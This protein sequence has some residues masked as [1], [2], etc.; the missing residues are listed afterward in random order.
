MWQTCLVYIA[1]NIVFGKD[2]DSTLSHLQQVLQR[3]REAHLKL[4]PS[5]CALFQK[6]VNFL[7][8]VVSAEGVRCDPSKISAIKDWPRP[9]NVREVRSILGLCG[10]YRRFIENFSEIAALLVNLTRKRV[11]FKW[12]DP[13]E[14]SFTQLKQALINAPILAYPT[15]DD[16][17]ILD[18]D[19]SAHSVRA[20]L[21]QLQ[22]GEQKVISYSSRTLS[23]SQRNYCTTK[24]E[25]LAIVIF[26]KQF[27]HYL[28][29]RKF[30]IRADHASLTWLLNFKEPEGML[31]RWISVL[32][33]YDFDIKHRPGHKHGN[34]D[35][36]SRI[37][38]KQCKRDECPEPQPS[39]RRAQEDN[40]TNAISF[41]DWCNSM[42]P[43]EL[44]QL[45]REDSAISQIISLIIF[46]PEQKPPWHD[47]S[48]DSRDVK[49]LWVQW[50]ALVI[51]DGI[52]YRRWHPAEAL[53]VPVCDPWCPEERNHAF[54][55]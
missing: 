27:R 49:T 8:H 50:R 17:F 2:F 31:V 39:V 42:S 6:S 41:A 55:T 20:V 45:Q 51:K 16:P 3:F 19:A 36:L 24:R 10:Y 46:F 21:S 14:K 18:T 9:R 11:Q 43:D 40:Q 32:D 25:L 5:K 34:A 23:H 28:W 26:V 15:Q 54:C 52:L 35:G 22:N 29:G 33:T 30:L 12:T 38:C 47:I 48:R 7:G 4:K 53:C 44:K 13:C 1:D 37:P